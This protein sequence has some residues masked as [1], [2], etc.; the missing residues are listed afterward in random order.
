MA[1]T[2]AKLR[3]IRSFFFATLGVSRECSFI[4]KAYGLAESSEHRGVTLWGY[5]NQLM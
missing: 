5:V 3:S 1:I 2:L 4:L